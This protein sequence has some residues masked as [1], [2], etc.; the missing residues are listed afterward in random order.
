MNLGIST[1]V[2]G[3]LGVM[4]L[5]WFLLAQ[6]VDKYLHFIYQWEK[7]KTQQSAISHFILTVSIS[8]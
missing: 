7:K 3:T 1:I 6:N 2:I 4:F 8:Y 5:L